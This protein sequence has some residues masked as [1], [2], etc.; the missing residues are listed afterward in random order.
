MW[1]TEVYKLCHFINK[2]RGE[3]I[4]NNTL[5]KPPSA[6]LRLNHKDSDSL[7]DYEILDG[8]LSDIIEYDM[9]FEQL[10]K[11]HKDV[12][13]IRRI[14]KTYQTSEYKRSQMPCSCKLTK[15]AYGSGRRVPIACKLTK[16]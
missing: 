16:I 6:E 12:N 5:T 9:S 11:N 7:P 13:L 14:I 10:V 3:V 8:I 1:K 4:P 2:Y 15:R